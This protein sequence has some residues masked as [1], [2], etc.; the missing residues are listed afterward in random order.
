MRRRLFVIGLAA[1]SAFAH[2][3]S[4]GAPP[5]SPVP[6]VPE[7]A[8]HRES[9]VTPIGTAPPPVAPH[10]CPGPKDH[11]IVDFRVLQASPLPEPP[12]RAPVR[13][14]AFGSCLVRVTDR[15][16][17]FP[18]DVASPG[19]RNEYSRVQSFNAD[20]SRI[21]V[22]GVEGSTYLYDATTLQPLARSVG[23]A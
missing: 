3:G 20:G 21:L 15:D 2:V 16:R 22:R 9:A 18:G 7:A 10:P 8:V 17:D 12:A 6:V 14:P 11:L 1:I 13:D 5:P 4:A 23:H 19:M